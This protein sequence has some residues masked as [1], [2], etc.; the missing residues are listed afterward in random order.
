MLVRAQ[1]AALLV[2]AVVCLGPPAPAAAAQGRG[3]VAAL[4]VALRSAG[5]YS[6]TVD[7]ILGPATIA[8]VRKLQRRAQLPVDGIAGAAHAARARATRA[9]SVR[10]PAAAPRAR[11]LGRRRAAVQ[12]RDARLS[13]R[14]DGRRAR[15][16]LDPRPASASRRG[17]ACARTAS[18]ARARSARCAALRRARP[19]SSCG[20][21]GPPSTTASARAATAS[22]RASTSRRPAARR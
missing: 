6:G 14:P 8:A 13:L 22:M 9:P 12:A 19:S 18:R 21:S 1:V 4:Q 15:P 7:G 10:Q 2:A 16:A 17:R 5:T 3:D 20:R 11:R